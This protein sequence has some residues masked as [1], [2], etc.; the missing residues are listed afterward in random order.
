MLCLRQKH[1]CSPLCFEFVKNFSSAGGQE[2]N[3]GKP[4][5]EI[6]L[7]LVGFIFCQK[8]QKS[9]TD[10]SRAKSAWDTLLQ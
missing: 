8:P 6:F 7:S 1:I 5:Q 10:I 4:C 9:G 3:S 2:I